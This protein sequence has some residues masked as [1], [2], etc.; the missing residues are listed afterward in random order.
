M[1]ERES[2]FHTCG[3]F[4]LRYHHDMMGRLQSALAFYD[5][6]DGNVIVIVNCASTVD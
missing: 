1:R 6:I 4:M 2:N 3:L 5:N